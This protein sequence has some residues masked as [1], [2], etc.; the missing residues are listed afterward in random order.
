MP[1][2][3]GG[4][5]EGKPRY[6]VTIPPELNAELQRLAEEHNMS[7]VELIRQFVRLGVIEERV[8]PFSFVD[9]HGKQV[10]IELFP[11]RTQEK[12]LQVWRTADGLLPEGH[13]SP[14]N[15]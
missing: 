14:E 8:G 7:V 1:N 9:E 10:E 4:R 6:N 13:Q 15:S 3:K 5:G 11:E 12:K 2:Q